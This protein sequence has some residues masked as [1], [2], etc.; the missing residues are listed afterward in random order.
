MDQSLGMDSSMGGGKTQALWK[1]ND[2]KA[3]KKGPHH[4]VF[5][6]QRNRKHLEAQRLGNKTAEEMFKVGD[7]YV[8]D[9]QENKKH[10]FGTMTWV[11]GNKYEGEWRSGK[12]S[13]K[14]TYWLKEGGKLRKHYTGDWADNK[15][16]GLGIAY[17]ENGDKYE[18]EWSGNMRHG[19][20]KMVYANGDI[21]EGD[22]ADD[23]RSGLGVLTMECGDRYEGH[24]LQDNKEGP[25][26]FFYL[27]THKLY[28]GE[29]VNDVAKCG[30]FADIPEESTFD[31]EYDLASVDNFSMPGLGLV[32]PGIVVSEAVACVR[33]ERAS[34]FAGE[35]EVVFTSQELE[36]LRLEF[37]CA[38]PEKRGLIRCGTLGSVLRGLGMTPA[39]DEIQLLLDD[40]NADDDTE[41]SFAEFVDIMALLSAA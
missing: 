29:W 3:A 36:Q 39:E 37:S 32:D 12:R 9:W 15:K 33:Q 6:V 24:W 18:G 2:A 40:L 27:A 21:F 41:I 5:W 4:T 11:K 31:R 34:T 17:Y 38:D 28:E 20:G 16:H 30:T 19:R 13:G 26:R 7:R 8:G 22:W 1:T 35:N 14:G 25:G 10:G 23:K